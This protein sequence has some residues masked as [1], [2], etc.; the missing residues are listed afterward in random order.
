MDDI[1]QEDGKVLQEKK[2]EGSMSESDQIF[3][4]LCFLGHH[5]R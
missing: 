4:A 2:K 5:E 3:V 1:F